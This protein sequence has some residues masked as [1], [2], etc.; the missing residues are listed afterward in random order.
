MAADQRA[1]RVFAPHST[2]ESSI[3]CRAG[4]S[5]RWCVRSGARANRR[6]PTH[7]ASRTTGSTRTIWVRLQ[8]ETNSTSVSLTRL[9]IQT[10]PSPSWMHCEQANASRRTRPHLHRP[11]TRPFPQ[12][13]PLSLNPQYR[14]QIWTRPST[15]FLRGTLST[16]SHWP[17]RTR[18]SS[19]RST[20]SRLSLRR[21]MCRRLSSLMSKAMFT[22]RNR[23]PFWTPGPIGATGAGSRREGKGWC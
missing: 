21:T 15:H 5:A 13:P 17:T 19:P 1:R 20:T 11:L 6:R 14:L 16:T 10:R 2:G 8:N 18:S 4:T 12:F 22:I 9:A 23:A 3:H 7:P